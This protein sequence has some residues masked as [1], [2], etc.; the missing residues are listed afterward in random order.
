[1][2]PKWQ[3]PVELGTLGINRYV[4]A[5]CEE[6][7]L[8]AIAAGGKVPEPGRS[9]SW[10][11]S[12]VL[13]LFPDITNCDHCGVRFLATDSGYRSF[14]VTTHKELRRIARGNRPSPWWKFW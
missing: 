10:S 8:E 14:W 9:K 3:L 6:A 11:P 12:E 1:M 2:A 5:E 4:H 7:F 13:D